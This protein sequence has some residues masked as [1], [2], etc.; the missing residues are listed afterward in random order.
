M[1]TGSAGDGLAPEFLVRVGGTDLP[2][3]AAADVLHVSVHEAVDAPAM[4][5]C[6]VVNWDPDT[7]AMKWSDGDLF[8]AGKELEIRLGYRD[9]LETLMTGE[10]T[11]L[12]LSVASREIPTLI[13]Q[14]YDRSH[15]LMRGRRLRTFTNVTD[16]EIARSVATDLSLTPEV[17]DT[18]QIFEYVLQCNQT[19]LEF[20]RERARRIGFEV[21]VRD[22]TM[23]F[24]PRGIGRGEAATLSRDSDLLEFRPRLSTLGP[25]P[26]V[27]VR[28]WN[29]QQKESL[30][31]HAD[32][33]DATATMG[34]A[35]LGAAAVEEIFGAA[36]TA[37]VARPQFSQ[38]EADQ[39]ARAAFNEAALSYISG[40]GVC[41]GRTDVRAGEVINI[42][43]LGERFSGPYYVT[44]ATHSYTPARGYRTRFAVRRNAS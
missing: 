33:G 40:E 7:V 25:S 20:L 36:E 41:V 11:A 15:R 22:K 32:T 16:A 14:G 6:E 42:A 23:F 5:M 12:E 3:R 10:I 35:T 17:A 38:A 13:V 18:Q 34:G 44:S 27:V 4:F 37:S 24:R 9:R 1:A 31:G 2:A 19:D 29:P 43:G 8:K 39:I 28:G 21:L 30:V 26:R